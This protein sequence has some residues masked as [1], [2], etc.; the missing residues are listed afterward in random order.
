MPAWDTTS[1]VR[2]IEANAQEL[3]E[4]VSL[5]PYPDGLRSIIHTRDWSQIM[6]LMLEQGFG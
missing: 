4:L 1:Y 2:G 5:L 6:T 3:Q